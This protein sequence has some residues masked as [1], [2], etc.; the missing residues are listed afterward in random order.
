[1]SGNRIG[2][3]TDSSARGLRLKEGQE[4]HAVIR[5]SNVMIATD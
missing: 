5:A 4:V 3:H 1:M 2:Y